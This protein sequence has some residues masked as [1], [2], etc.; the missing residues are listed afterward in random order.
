[1]DRPARKEIHAFLMH[2]RLDFSEQT[3]VYNYFSFLDILGLLGGLWATF[4]G[5]AAQLAVLSVVFYVY[6][7]AEMIRRKDAQRHRFIEIKQYQKHLPQIR[8]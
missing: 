3:V 6:K 2:L 1:M 7:L 5:L 8:A 4:N